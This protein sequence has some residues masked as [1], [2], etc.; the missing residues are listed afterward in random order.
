MPGLTGLSNLMQVAWVTPDLDRTM[1]EFGE[2]FGIEEFFFT[3]IAFPA[4]LF[5]ETGEMSIRLALANIDAMQIELIQ[6]V[7]GGLDRIYREA[8]PADGSHANVVHHVCVKIDGPIEAWE[9]Y[10]AELSKRTPIG[11]TGDSGPNVRFAYTDER[12]TLGLWL[13]HVW[14]EPEYDAQFSALIPTYRSR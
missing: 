2:R 7:G 3:D 12:A 1:A 5:D 11:Y 6:P 10:E 8:L 14:Y 9:A 4:R 13:E